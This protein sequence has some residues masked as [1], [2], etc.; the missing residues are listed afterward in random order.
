MKRCPT[1]QE[2]FSDKFKFCPVDST[3]LAS[4]PSEHVSGRRGGAEQLP[5]LGEAET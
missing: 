1:C 5:E 4:E 3:P 2:E